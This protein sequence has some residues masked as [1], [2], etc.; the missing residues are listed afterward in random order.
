[1]NTARLLLAAGA[2]TGLALAAASLLERTSAEAPLPDGVVARVGEREI[3]REEYQRAVDALSSDRRTPLGP[4][5]RRF[6]LDRMIEE[7]LLIQHALALGLA[8]RDRR[9]RADLVSAVMGSL[10]ASTDG[11]EPSEDELQRFHAEH[12]GYFAR[13]GRVQLRQIFVGSEPR[14][15]EALAFARAQQ[16]SQRLRAGEPFAQLRT[17][18]G[19]ALV[20]EIP[21]APLPESELTHYIG[22]SAVRAAAALEVGA[23]S[24][25]LRGSQGFHVL[26]LVSRQPSRTP[27]LAEIRDQVRAEL[28]RRAG[29]RAVRE[30]LDTLRSAVRVRI[31]DELP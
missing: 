1:V 3:R 13:P 7:E 12:A 19:D 20:A 10:V 15:T 28:V 8:Q 21:D 5:D 6:V 26:Q 16:A 29:D 9:V 22:P 2:A 25:P 14:R 17:E 27:P 23:T 24:D 11:Y 30:R 4:A 31:A 18:L